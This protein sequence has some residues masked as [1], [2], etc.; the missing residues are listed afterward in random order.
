M[1]IQQLVN[2]VTGGAFDSKFRE[3][4][5][6]SEREIMKQ[7]ARYINAAEHF[8]RAYPE[9]DDIRI[10]SSPVCVNIGEEGTYRQGGCVISAAAT[11]DIIAVTGANEDGVIRIDSPNFPCCEINI[12]G[13]FT[14]EAKKSPYVE[15]VRGVIAAFVGKN[16]SSYGINAY[17]SSDIPIDTGFSAA[18]A[19]ENLMGIIINNYYNNGE[20][21]AE[22]I[23][24][25]SPNVNVDMIVGAVGG[26]VSAE[27]DGNAPIIKAIDYDFS[28]LGY[29]VCI[30]VA[31]SDDS[32]NLDDID[33]MT[34]GMKE[35]AKYF[36][37]SLLHDIDEDEFYDELPKMRK[38]C[39]DAAI[40]SA[41]RFFEENRRAADAVKALGIGDTEEFFRLVDQSGKYTANQEAAAVVA[42]SRRFLGESGAVHVCGGRIVQVFVPSYIAVEYTEK[43]NSF[44]GEE[45][46]RILG[47]RS[48]GVTEIIF[49]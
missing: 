48:K 40:L 23:A 19:F 16:F 15:I 34:R 31:G 20:V 11:I 42:V 17:I 4:Y 32:E 27:F 47:I 12:D 49:N 44:L 26:L 5:G 30:T 43:M 39:S 45:R 2:A 18:A 13:G 46:C 9:C 6:N 29:S 41:I 35:A 38:C 3:L 33:E 10:F 21:S 37:K 14:N 22:K 24:M 36:G 28:S 25:S 8:S 1:T 7:R